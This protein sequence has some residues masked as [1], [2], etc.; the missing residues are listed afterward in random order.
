MIFFF[1]NKARVMVI[2]LK[3]FVHEEH[4]F[5]FLDKYGNSLYC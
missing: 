2:P 3:I 5:F 1:K 4:F